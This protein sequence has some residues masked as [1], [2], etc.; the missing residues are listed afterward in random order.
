MHEYGCRQFYSIL[1]RSISYSNFNCIG[2]SYLHKVMQILL[3]MFIRPTT[4]DIAKR[5]N[6]LLDYSLLLVCIDNGF[7][8]T[9]KIIVI[10]NSIYCVMNYF[11]ASAN[12]WRW[13]LSLTFIRDNPPSWTHYLQQPLIKD[14]AIT[15]GSRT[16]LR[17][18]ILHVKEGRFTFINWSKQ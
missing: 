10:R 15:R 9:T 18:C 16:E 3:I 6:F 12:R 17:T 13:D 8:V 11:I 2:L 14:E 4:T 5:N 1:K 7:F